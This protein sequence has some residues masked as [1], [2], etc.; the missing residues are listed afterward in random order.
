MGRVA[1]A[2]EARGRTALKEM[3]YS[4]LKERIVTC[5]LRPGEVLCEQELATEF[6]MSRTPLR[7]ALVQL[8]SESLVRLEPRRGTFVAELSVR[9]IV[10]I[11]ELREAVETWVV[12]AALEKAGPRDFARFR[13]A[14]D[15]MLA[16]DE[17]DYWRSISLDAEFHAYLVTLAGNR[18]SEAFYRNLQDHDQRIRVLSSREP[19]RIAASLRE[20]LTIV[21]ALEDGDPV[22]AASAMETHIRNARFAAL[23]LF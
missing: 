19:G 4:E 12:R 9:D 13:D 8:A 21:E 16:G 2:A 6:G 18:R 10:E 11:F 1:V 23:R 7:E 3:A 22:R 20:H 5:R 14:F 15:A 17:P